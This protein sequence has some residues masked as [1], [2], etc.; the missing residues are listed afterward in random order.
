MIIFIILFILYFAWLGTRIFQGTLEGVESFDNFGDAGFWMLVLLTTANFPN[1]MLPAYKNDRWNCL[2]FIFFLIIALFLLMNLLLAIFY[3]N[4][5]KRYENSISE[6]E[7]TRS[8][9]L[10]DK[11]NELDKENKGYL[12]KQE[13]FQMIQEIHSLDKSSRG[14]FTIS[15]ED[16]ETLFHE[17][18]ADGSG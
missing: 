18:D 5:K 7:E 12:D 14:K 11:F 10:N 16:F 4:Y 13:G 1:F 15:K 17:L 2:F 8:K 3:S 6:L 9:Y